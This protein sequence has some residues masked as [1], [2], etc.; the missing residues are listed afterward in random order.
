MIFER[1][2]TT[3]GRAAEQVERAARESASGARIFH[4]SDDAVASGGVVMGKAQAERFAS[5]ARNGERA[6]DELGQADAA[7]GELGTILVRAQ[8]IAIQA[9]NDSASA[10]GRRAAGLEVEAMIRGAAAAL[11]VKVGNRYVFAGDQSA[12]PAWD[13]D[14][15]FVGDTGVRSLEVAPGIFLDTSIR[16]DQVVNGTAGGIDVFAVL[17]DLAAALAADDV[18]AIRAGLD[19]YPKAI[20]QVA[21]GRA[22]AGGLMNVLAS[23][24]DAA[25]AGESAATID[26]GRMADADP[27]DAASRLALAQHAL[28]AALTVAAQSFRLSL[29]DKLR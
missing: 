26:V 29:L 3:T 17:R 11:N 16:A 14:G 15:N 6:L 9:S 28:D 20:A 19:D 7:L 24:V 5:I 18:P 8:Q 13:V 4:P 22:S 25:K 10:E 27:I 2:L 12:S 1:G 23:S 21:S